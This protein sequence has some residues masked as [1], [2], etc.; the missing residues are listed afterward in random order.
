MGFI[1]AALGAAAGTLR[2][3]WK[4]FFYA[5]ALPSD[6]IAVKARASRKGLFSNRGN[7]NVI[8][9]GSG[10][11]VADGQCAVIVEQGKVVDLCAEPG[12]YTY[13]NT[14]APS[15]LTGDLSDTVRATFEEIG[16]RFTYGGSPAVDQRIYYFNT[17]EMTGNKFGT[18]NPIPFRVVDS[19]AG[20]DMDVSIKCFGE[21]SFRVSNPILFYTNNA[22]NFADEYKVEMISSQMR[23]ELL[24]ALQPA[25]A[26][27][28]EEGIR[29][30]ALPGKTTELCAAL[31]EELKKVWGE[32]RGIEIQSIAISSVTA[33]ESDEKTLKQM[34]RSAAYTDPSLAAAALVG[35]QAQAMQDAANNPAGAVNGFVGMNMAQSAG[36][37]D[38]NS[39]YARG[40]ASRAESTP[41]AKAEGEWFCPSCGTKNSGNFCTNCGTKKPS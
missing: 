36:G 20:I 41:Q 4:E 11:V 26:R 34:Q 9:S 19:K 16:R 23:S 10:V 40:S 14:A 3:T 13:D 18:P 33:D 32:Q 37:A 5:D 22:G 1:R 2:D 31:K 29:Y 28:S 39:L 25:F 6:V 35:A 12:E 38:V 7:D 30:S 17:K 8:T 24:N 27:I 21:Y 15:I